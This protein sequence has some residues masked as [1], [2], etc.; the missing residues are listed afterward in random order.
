MIISYQVDWLLVN[1]LPVN[2]T[3]IITYI[4]YIVRDIYSTETQR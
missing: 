1:W 4:T 3:Y 2:F